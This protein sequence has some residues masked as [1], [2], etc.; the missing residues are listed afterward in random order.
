MGHAQDG[1]SPALTPALPH[2][3]V[4]RLDLE[5]PN[6]EMGLAGGAVATT[7]RF[8]RLAWSPSGTES[9]ELPVRRGASPRACTRGLTRPSLCRCVSTD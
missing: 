8:H 1:T 3:Q 5:S 9:G 6:R 4:Y 7:E 2:P